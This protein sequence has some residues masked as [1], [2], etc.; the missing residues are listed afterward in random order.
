MKIMN[1]KGMCSSELRI[2]LM[3]SYWKRNEKA[4][5][6]AGRDTPPEVS[7][8]PCWACRKVTES[9]GD[10]AACREEVGP[11]QKRQFSGT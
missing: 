5:G 9:G 1:I 2:V 3:E 6:R 8:A 7:W 11:V 10:T 4:G